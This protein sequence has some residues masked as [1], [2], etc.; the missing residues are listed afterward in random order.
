MMEL[1]LCVLDVLM[2]FQVVH[3]VCSSVFNQVFETVAAS[4]ARLLYK[5]IN[6]VE[7]ALTAAVSEDLAAFLTKLTKWNTRRF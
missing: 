5:V 7:E 3:C 1:M 6:A 4:N 2:M